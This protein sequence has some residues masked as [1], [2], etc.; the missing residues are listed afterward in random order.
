MKKQRIVLASVLKPVDDTR[1]F[2]KIGKSLSENSHFEIFII[3]YASKQPPVDPKITFLPHPNFV[4][5]SLTRAL[6]P[7]IIL[8]KIYKVKPEA[9]I[10]NTHELLIVA[11]LYRIFFGAKIIYDVQENYW[12]NILWTD[13]FP[14][15]FK[16]PIACW[17]RMKE[18]VLS[19]FIRLFL[20]AEKGFEKE[21]K[22]F[23]NKFIILENKSTLPK[24]FERTKSNG[25]IKLLFS[26]TIS[27]STGVF[28]AINLTNMLH[29]QDPS[30]SL[31]IVGYCSITHTLNEVKKAIKDKP[32]ILLTGGDQLVPHHEILGQISS[33]DFGI[34]YYPASPHIENKIP[35]KL[36]EYLSAQLPMLIQNY[37]PWAALCQP[38]QAAIPI[39]F[40]SP[41]DAAAL[42]QKMKQTHFYTTAPADVLWASEE[43]KLHDAI[44]KV[45]V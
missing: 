18:I 42:L 29:Q 21:M 30:V 11:N 4:R 36:Y 12:R 23:Q 22:F 43:K 45:L 16:Y 40:K 44:N 17:V 3:G 32:F 41:I 8:K 33:S 10:V 2:E 28:E 13:T 14:S 20:L 7:L 34:I 35:T 27:E 1:M 38:Y 9:I 6:M 26:G 25:V 19:R 39:D 37:P 24:G 31:H 5:L 15:L